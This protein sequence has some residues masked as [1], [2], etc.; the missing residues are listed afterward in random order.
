[1]SISINQASDFDKL[2]AFLGLGSKT[3]FTIPE[4]LIEHLIK[5]VKDWAKDKDIRIE[6]TTPSG[7]KLAG[8]TAAGVGCGVI[9]G[10][11]LAFSLPG[12]VAAG[13]AGGAIGFAVAHTTI[14]VSP[15]SAAG[16]TTVTIA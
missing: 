11:A 8:C 6:F 7:A 9:A 10:L 1:M 12:V 4:H 2:F 13:V 5:E 14:V 3:S 15:A 16:L